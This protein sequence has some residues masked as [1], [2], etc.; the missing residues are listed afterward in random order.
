MKKTLILAAAAVLTAVNANAGVVTIGATPEDRTNWVI[1]GCGQRGA[2]NDTDKG[3]AAIKDG[4]TGT[5]WHSEWGT[6][7]GTDH[8]FVIDRGEE[9]TA[10]FSAFGY[11]PRIGANAGNGYVTD[12]SIYVLDS[13]DGLEVCEQDAVGTGNSNAHSSLATFLNDKTPAKSGH[14]DIAYNTTSTHYERIEKFDTPQSGR[15]VLFVANHTSGSQGDNHANCSEFNLYTE[16]IEIPTGLVFRAKFRPNIASGNNY[17]SYWKVDGENGK[18]R[19]AA[20][21]D[22]FVPERLWYFKDA[23]SGKLTIHSIAKT[24]N[25]GLQFTTTTNQAGVFSTT[26]TTLTPKYNAITDNS[27]SDLT[28]F[29]LQISGNAYVNDAQNYIGVWNNGNAPTGAGSTVALFYITEADI[30]GVAGASDEAKAAAKANA[31]PENVKA[32]LNNSIVESYTSELRNK[33]EQ[34]QE[35]LDNSP[36][37][38]PGY[39]SHDFLNNA[40]AAAEALLAEGANPSMEALLDIVSNWPITSTTNTDLS[41]ANGIYKIT[42]V[43]ADNRG[44][45]YDNGNE[46]N[47][48]WTSGKS[49]RPESI[50]EA[51]EHWAVIN[52]NGGYLIYNVGS[53]KFLVAPT[54]NGANNP[55]TLSDQTASYITIAAAHSNFS[56]GSVEFHSGSIDMSISNSY[57]GPLTSYYGATD[58]GV[59]FKFERVGELDEAIH[60]EMANKFFTNILES[61]KVYTITNTDTANDR[62]SLVFDGTHEFIN[63][64]HNAGA[65]DAANPN[66]QW[67][68]VSDNGQ[69]FLYNLGAQ[70]FANAY[71]HKR[72][73]QHGDGSWAWQ[74]AE[75]G[76]PVH[77]LFQQ[78]RNFSA[79]RIMGGENSSST[80]TD[81]VA[82][83]MVI[84]ANYAPVPN[85]SHGDDGNGFTFAEVEGVSVDSE[86]IKSA[87]NAAVANLE[88][89]KSSANAL[90]EGWD[91]EVSP[92]IVG[93]FTTE[94][95]NQFRADMSAI[96]SEDNA[97]K[98]HGIAASAVHYLNN[99]KVGLTSG[100]VY[101]VEVVSENGNTMVFPEEVSDDQN[102]DPA[103]GN[104]LCTIAEDGT[105]T[106]THQFIE[107]GVQTTRAAGDITTSTMAIHGASAFTVAHTATPGVVTLNSNGQPIDS[108]SYVITNK[109]NADYTTSG[110][111]EILAGE[112][113]GDAVV[114]D[115]MGR[116]VS[117]AGKGI[118][119]VNGKKTLVK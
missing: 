96:N 31:T 79:F 25:Q 2:G 9:A 17:N 85:W 4:N 82:G 61:G 6:D 10:T 109:P 83:M 30:D 35:L 90:V 107:R 117:K 84:N 78:T 52:L 36:A 8:F 98:Q 76:T 48:V 114:Y 20:D 66:H 45:I 42:N 68:V 67:T 53:K 15:Y 55:W 51:N 97:S 89:Y 26:P 49:A 19:I 23:G 21:A 38:T 87:M 70:K 95:A 111:E 13:V 24:D 44:Y 22:A 7:T 93:H 14:W 88:A 80:E 32:L 91:E 104:W 57:A 113:A 119:I 81:D 41:V 99:G 77:L 72:D 75:V 50:S 110:I 62:G 18:T 5:H 3:F 101:T 47:Y 69:Y 12:Y 58:N 105:A 16:A 40:I 100:A 37:N 86:A 39:Y 11:T 28:G 115:L 34:A 60:S 29:T 1:T 92:L 63:T 116:R 102:I 64:T 56:T 65:L 71:F 112:K 27:N 59:P 108:N 46:N 106:F 103:H 73:Q 54:S 94:A 33:V 118:Y 74:L 43:G